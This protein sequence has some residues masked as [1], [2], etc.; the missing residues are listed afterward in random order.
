[1]GSA[2]G[3]GREGRTKLV[4]NTY[5]EPDITHSNSATSAFIRYHKCNNLVL[6]L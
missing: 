6:I 3:E 4:L 2:L 1:M 5:S